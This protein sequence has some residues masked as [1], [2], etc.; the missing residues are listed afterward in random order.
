MAIC[1]PNWYASA[2]G[3]Y[4]LIYVLYKF[5]VDYGHCWPNHAVHGHDTCFNE[6][7]A[8]C[9]VP[10]AGHSSP[11]DRWRLR[12]RLLSFVGPRNLKFHRL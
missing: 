2:V 9:R 3:I 7:F 8:L 11:G 4:Q 5:R 12:V 10:K 1:F 6:F